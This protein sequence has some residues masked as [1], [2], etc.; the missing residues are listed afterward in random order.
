MRRD[1][2]CNLAAAANDGRSA[3]RLAAADARLTAAGLAAGRG[4]S[5]AADRSGLAAAGLAATGLTA[6]LHVAAGGFAAAGD[7]NAA[8]RSRSGAAGR[9][10][11]F[12]AGA[13][14]AAG[15]LAA[16]TG[17]ETVEQADTGGLTTGNR[18]T[19]ADGGFATATRLSTVG[20]KEHQASRDR[21][22]NHT[23]LHRGT[24]QKTESE[25][26]R[27]HTWP[28]RQT[29]CSTRHIRRGGRSQTGL[30]VNRG[31]SPPPIV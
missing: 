2:Q 13:D 23:S 24:P 27:P 1:Q 20:A 21:G 31:R 9:G 15:G 26:H 10:G 8:G 30:S 18:L 29:R 16:L 6:L 25:T 11:S 17:M 14:F 12:A 3:S 22:E 7:F 4:R 5:R 19:T 28:D